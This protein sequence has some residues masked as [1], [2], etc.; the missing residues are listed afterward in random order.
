MARTTPVVRDNILTRSVDRREH[1][2]YVGTP[3]WY[4]WLEEV[5]T[6]AFVN[7]TGTFTARKEPGQHGGIYWKAYRKRDGKLHHAY[8]GKSQDITLERLNAVAAHLCGQGGI[9]EQG[10]L[11]NDALQV[12]QARINPLPAN[13]SVMQQLDL[14]E[15]VPQHNLPPQLTS[16][17]GREQ[18]TAAAAQL[19]QHPEV[20]LLTLTGP[21]GVGKTRLALEVARRLVSDFADGVYMVSL[22]P[23]SDPDLVISTIARRLGLMES[24]SQPVLELLKVSQRDRRRLLL[25]DNFE[26][27]VK[28]SPLL[29]ELLEACP[30]L[31][32]LITSRE[33]LRL[34]GEQQFVVPP[35]AIPDLKHLPDAQSLAHI[36]AVNLFNQRAQAIHSDFQLTTDNAA[37]IAEICLRLDGLPLAIELAAARIKLLPPQALLA[38]LDRRLY[39]LTE[40]ARDLPE[41]QWTLRNTLAWSY[42]LLTEEE[43]QLYRRLSV[44]VGGCT[45]E[46]IEAVYA[47]LRD[48]VDHML[49]GVASLINK[50]LLQQ[51]EQVTEEPRFV[52]L[53][54][55]REFGLER[56]AASGEAEAMR[57]VHATYFLEV[58]LESFPK[59]DSAEQF[60]WFKRLEADHDN[61]RAALRW[62][63]ERQEAQMGL[64]LASLLGAGFWLYC[65]HER[66]GGSW[67]AQVLGQPGAEVR[68]LARAKALRGLGLLLWAQGDFP[69]AQQVLEESVSIG[70]EIGA[71]GTF[72]LAGALHTLAHVALEQGRLGESRELAGE[73]LR[74]FQE[75]GVTWGV[76]LALHH[77]GMATAELGDPGAARP[78]L[79]ESAALLRVVGN[80]LVLALPIDA[81][82]QMALRQ[83]DYAGA[84]TYFEEALSVARETGYKQFTAD[85]LAHLGTVALRMGEYHKAS[86]YYQQ[87][88]VLNHEQGY[89]EGIVEDLAGLAEMASLLGQPERAVRLIGAVEALREA[90]G[91]RLSPLRRSEY[92]RAVECIRAQV[93]EAVFAVAWKEGRAMPLEQLVAQALETKDATLTEPIPGETGQEEALSD[94]TP[95]PP[96]EL[97]AREMEVLLLLAQGLTSAQIAKRLVIGL[98]TVNSH[99]RSIYS[100]LGITSR[101]AATRYA[102]EHHL[103]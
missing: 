12:Q 88:L 101:A 14:P 36:P 66:E 98:V 94:L 47:A 92:E 89:Q 99:V 73:S 3:D 38:R 17:V 43:Q 103:L 37:V 18:D 74:L 84:Q 40:G 76:A 22:A 6:F 21:A 85:A 52:M 27:V 93:D 95:T 7:D 61:L 34:R 64:L 54:T 35:L 13:I 65:N 53:E 96:H 78:L 31:K 69:E 20:R 42:E 1:Q 75:L 9:R 16:L 55:I 45:L 32:L 87:S 86:L 102:L 11:G 24:G 63:L 80:K 70:R 90:S 15:S 2:L 91:I 50:S 79:E 49:D 28:A 4:T 10:L 71:P 39:V 23:L 25:L 46:A 77:I 8:L 82:G 41:R 68:T 51:T 26:Q 48:D 56:L 72:D 57:R 83:G 97:T 29:S 19:L 81:L 62:T 60:A 30:D 100:K 44:F 58:A 67:L 59:I 5:S 33:V